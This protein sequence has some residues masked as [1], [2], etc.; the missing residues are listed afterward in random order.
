MFVWGVS[1]DCAVH[2]NYVH[3]RLVLGLGSR[4]KQ[5][6]PSLA[7]FC[8][9][10]FALRPISQVSGYR[11]PPHRGP[12]VWHSPDQRVNKSRRPAASGVQRQGATGVCR[13]ACSYSGSRIRNNNQQSLSNTQFFT[14]RPPMPP[15]DGPL[16]PCIGHAYLVMHAERG[17]A[18][19]AGHA[20]RF[21]PTTDC[22]M[23][24]AETCI[25]GRSVH[26]PVNMS[27]GKPTTS[28]RQTTVSAGRGAKIR[29]TN[30]NG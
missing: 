23:F 14:P 6:H 2:S 21:M 4:Q 11:T 29:V 15:T 7:P 5:T 16:M 9:P 17:K 25:R 20:A 10:S 26:G 19:L 22:C 13:V 8:G 30:R 12:P 27:P 3:D 24:Q 1:R 28:G 18:G